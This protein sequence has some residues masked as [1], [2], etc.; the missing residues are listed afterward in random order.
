M[1]TRTVLAQESFTIDGSYMTAIEAVRDCY[2][3]VDV[4]QMHLRN[5]VMTAVSTGEATWAEIAAATGKRSRQSAFDYFTKEWTV[6]P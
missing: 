4:A 5:A 3:S 1:P 6:V 2:R